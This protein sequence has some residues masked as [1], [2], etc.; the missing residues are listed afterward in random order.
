MHFK[1]ASVQCEMLKDSLHDPELAS[2]CLKSINEAMNESV[3][4]NGSQHLRE[5]LCGCGLDSTVIEMLNMFNLS[6]EVQKECLISVGS[7][8]YRSESRK[9]RLI[10]LGAPNTICNTLDKHNNCEP[11]L[12]EGLWACGNLSA[13]SEKLKNLLFQSDI[14]NKILSTLQTHQS[15]SNIQKTGLIFIGN[16]SNG[17][18]ARNVGL[19]RAGALLACTSAIDRFPDA[20]DVQA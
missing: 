12:E 17:S 1:F 16:L 5:E 10:D 18:D 9:V 8:A 6:E 19:M 13:G 14:V 11:V 3:E 7:L 20:I 2:N 15:N 4:T